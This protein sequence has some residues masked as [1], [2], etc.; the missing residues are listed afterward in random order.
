M[1]LTKAIAM[2]AT[3]AIKTKEFAPKTCTKAKTKIQEVR[4]QDEEMEQ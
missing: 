4:E 1:V 2:M 3:A